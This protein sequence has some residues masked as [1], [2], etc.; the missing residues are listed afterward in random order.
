M[1]VLSARQGALAWDP[2]LERLPSHLAALVP[3]S[4]ILIYPSEVP[5]SGRVLPFPG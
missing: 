1:V 5:L 3:E 4:F 2:A